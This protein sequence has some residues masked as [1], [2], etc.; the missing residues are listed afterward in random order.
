MEKRKS[1]PKI[2]ITI[3]RILQWGLNIAL[4]SLALILCGLLVKE[5]IHLTQLAFFESSPTAYFELLEGILVF[6]LYFEFIAMI[7]KYFQE[8]YH[9]PLR[10]FMYIGITAMVRLIVVDHEDAQQT[11]LFSVSILVLVISYVLIHYMHTKI[12]R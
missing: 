4:V 7:V 9:F 2:K 11:L 12:K 3:D 5:T 8:D 6:F 10:Y 1:E